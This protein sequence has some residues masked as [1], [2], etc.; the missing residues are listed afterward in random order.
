LIYDKNLLTGKFKGNEIEKVVATAADA[1][2]TIALIPLLVASFSIYVSYYLGIG[3]S[4]IIISF[5]SSRFLKFNT[6]SAIL[7]KNAFL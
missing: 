5:S 6:E 1:A 2:S 3:I 4:I 7:S